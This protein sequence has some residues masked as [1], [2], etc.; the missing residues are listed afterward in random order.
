MAT[1]DQPKGN[2]MGGGVRSG[3]APRD[4]IETAIFEVFQ[5]L[6]DRIPT[7]AERADWASKL[8]R[9][10]PMRTL[11]VAL[12]ASPEHATLRA[13]SQDISAIR[14]TGLFDAIWY[15]RRYPD[16]EDAGMSPAA[17]YAAHGEREDRAPNPWFDPAWYRLT[18]GLTP[19]DRPLFH[20]VSVGEARGLRPSPNFD[21]IWY[22]S[23]YNLGGNKQPLVDFLRRRHT[24]TVAPSAALWAALGLPEP[25]LSP[26]ADDVFLALGEEPPDMLVLRDEG[27]FDENYYALHS[28]DVL[29]SGA[30]L[31]RHYCEFGWR[32]QR[33]PNFYFDSRWY[34]AT[35]PEVT[36]LNVNPLAHYLLVGEPEGRRPIVFFDPVWYRETYD[37]P[38]EM[39]SLAHFL[40]HRRQ[41]KVA[42]NEFFDPAWYAAQRGEIIRPGRDPF[43]RFLVAGLTED[44]SPSPR[45]DLADWRHKSM[46]R[47]SRHF[48]HLLDPAKDNPLVNYLLA[49]YR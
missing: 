4:G 23:A 36:Q 41:G 26:V 22:R 19:Q 13:L 9:G 47:V 3:A 30:D 33:Q 12:E 44:I 24:R 39:S 21:P 37:V 11:R 1:G 48:R 18:H 35:N 16:I 10:I 43:A 29:A 28:G 34:A 17:H 38:E 2:F 15:K 8:A 42:P 7:Q 20:Y 40:A 27:L 5:E 32:E 31:L 49:T 45:F 46:G 6:V 14:K 25:Q